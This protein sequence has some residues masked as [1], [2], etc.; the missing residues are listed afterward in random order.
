MAKINLS[1]VRIKKLTSDI[2][3]K[4]KKYGI[5]YKLVKSTNI[6]SNGSF[7]SGYF[8]SSNMKLA[9]AA[10][11]KLALEV[12]THESCHLDQWAEGHKAFT[13]TDFQH[14]S[15]IIECHYLFDLWLNGIIELDSK[16]LDLMVERMMDCERDCE[17]RTVRKLQKYKLTDLVNIDEYCQKSN[18]YIL[19]YRLIRANRK[20]FAKGKSPYMIP[21]VYEMFPK[22]IKSATYNMPKKIKDVMNQNCFKK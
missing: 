18:A 12:L 10:Y 13:G 21:E 8:D 11:N 22:T 1:D 16:L 6:R 19:G 20:W 4:C 14:Q 5:E 7:I 17:K 9:S 15:H 2:K 3:A